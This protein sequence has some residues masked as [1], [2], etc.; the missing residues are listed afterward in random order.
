LDNIEEFWRK[1]SL[2]NDELMRSLANE[3]NRVFKRHFSNTWVFEV[4]IAILRKGGLN[5]R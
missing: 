5:Q 1:L 3:P 4:L 2:I